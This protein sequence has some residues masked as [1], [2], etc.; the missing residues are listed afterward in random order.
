MNAARVG[1]D[2]S[3]ASPWGQAGGGRARNL[4]LD[5]PINRGTNARSF[6]PAPDQRE[7]GR[8]TRECPAA[9]A[10]SPSTPDHGLQI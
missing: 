1:E 6:R 2:A 10:P 9:E 7:R 8:R 3:R 4:Q 5:I